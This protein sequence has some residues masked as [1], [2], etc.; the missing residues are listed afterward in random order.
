MSQQLNEVAQLIHERIVEHDNNRMNA[1][2]L[3]DKDTSDLHSAIIEELQY[4]Y[5]YLMGIKNRVTQ[6]PCSIEP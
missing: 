5:S 2:L 6:E 3:G 1:E 4:L